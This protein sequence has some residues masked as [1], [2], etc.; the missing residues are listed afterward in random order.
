MT[1]AH[2]GEWWTNAWP[3]GDT[4]EIGQDNCIF[5][6]LLRELRVETDDQAWQDT[7]ENYVAMMG[8]TPSELED[9]RVVYRVK[10]YWEHVCCLAVHTEFLKI[11]AAWRP[12]PFG[13]SDLLQVA[14]SDRYLLNIGLLTEGIVFP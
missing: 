9:P 7:A 10:Y 12:C 5:A 3:G 11:S 13:T 14:R 4:L 8:L 1:V 2:N 6:K